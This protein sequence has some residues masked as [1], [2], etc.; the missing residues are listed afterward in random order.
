LT[1]KL[2][3]RE[4]KTPG[5]DSMVHHSDEDMVGVVEMREPAMRGESDD[6][7]MRWAM[8]T[9]NSPHIGA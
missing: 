8:A 4:V 1:P 6:E 2:S 3:M 9:I 5:S 7:P